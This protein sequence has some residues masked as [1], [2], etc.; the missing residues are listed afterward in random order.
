MPY[1]T[2]CLLSATRSPC[3]D[4]TRERNA[5]ILVPCLESTEDADINQFVTKYNE[6]LSDSLLSAEGIFQHTLG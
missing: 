1:F 4:N 2:E 5:I 6:S 3:W